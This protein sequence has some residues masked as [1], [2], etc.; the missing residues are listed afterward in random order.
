MT[1]RAWEHRLIK[2][3]TD[4][5]GASLSGKNWD[6]CNTPGSRAVSPEVGGQKR[7][8]VKLIL[9]Y[10]RVLQIPKQGKEAPGLPEGEFHKMVFLPC[11]KEHFPP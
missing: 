5:Q 4:A 7:L 1:S 8:G 6:F 9:S 2:I 3:H 11:Y 10:L